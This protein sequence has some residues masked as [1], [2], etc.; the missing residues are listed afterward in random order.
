M[1]K[2]LIA[3][4]LVGLVSTSCYEKLNI[5]PPNSI[6][7][8]QVMELLRTGNDETVTSIMGAL[9]EALPAQIKGG[10]YV[11]F[12]Q[13]YYAY[14]YQS[15]G[16]IREVSGN[17][18][19]LGRTTPG[20]DIGNLYSC[21]NLTNPAG[22]DLLGYWK[23][24]YALVHAANKVFNILTEEM[25]DNSPSKALKSYAGWGYITRAYGYLWLM[26]NFAY[27][28]DP[29]NASQL[30]VP[31]YTVYSDAQPLKAR[32]PQTEVYDSIFKWLDKGIAYMKEGAV[33]QGNN[34]TQ[35]GEG[36]INLGFAYFIQAR[37]ALCAHKWD[38]AVSACDEL[39]INSNYNYI[40]QV[41]DNLLSN[42]S[43]FTH[44]GSVTLAYE[45][46]KETNQL[47]F[48]VTDT[49]IGIPIDEQEHVFERF[50][51]L[52]NFSQGAGLGLSICRIVAERLGGFLIIDRE[53]TQGTRFIFCVSM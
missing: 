31:I 18:V 50:V 12:N 14:N 24:G 45:V 7:N 29:S 6:T 32:A 37:A 42:A 41:L 40:V 36:K 25:V 46:K 43:K 2:Y 15:Q 17:D 38:V 3:L 35:N 27:P 21:T 23:R 19:V 51:K 53:Y 16:T 48:T 30:G 26:E 5:A 52:D 39:I 11:T 1:K 8:E 49:G 34:F 10:G 4:S 44:E 28:Y 22:D 9:A 13:P 20:G 33:D 47:I